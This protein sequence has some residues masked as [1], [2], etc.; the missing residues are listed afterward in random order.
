MS[1]SAVVSDTSAVP[2]YHP[3]RGLKVKL[4]ADGADKS[5]ML[6]LCA[7]PLIAGLTT[8]P[9]LMRKAG[10]SNYEAFA[11][12]I[13]SSITDK[14][15]SFEVFSDEASEMRRHAMQI[16]SWGSNVYVKI[17][18]TNTRGESMM[19]L[20]QALARE[21]VKLNVTALLTLRQVADVAAALSESVPA[22][23]SVFAGRIADTGT[24]PEPL[25]RASRCLLEERPLA[26]LLWASVREVLNIFQADSCGCDIVTVPH[27]ILTKAIKMAG[28]SL[29]A[30]SLDTVRMFASDAAAAGFHL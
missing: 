24:D 1:A 3:L 22:V 15:I 5:G 26:E 16:A 18:V 19:P 2:E 7:N 13:L 17:P 30:V 6:T 4:F 11:K 28:S 9:T 23:V 27:D 8:N 21:G 10:I 29:D 14:P 25:M 20:V 12:D